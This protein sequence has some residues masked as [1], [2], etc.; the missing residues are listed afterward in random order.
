MTKILEI[1]KVSKYLSW[2]QV[3]FNVNLEVLEWEIYGFLWPNWAGKTT[4]MKSIMWLIKPESWEIK[5][6]WEVWL[7]IEAKKQ[8]GFMPENTYLYKYLTGKEFLRFNWKFFWLSWDKL[9]KKVE[10]LLEKVWLESAWEKYL[11]EYSKW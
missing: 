3:L 9:E 1:N 8:I 7:T 4:T 6:F 10:E 11:N 5:L 2:N